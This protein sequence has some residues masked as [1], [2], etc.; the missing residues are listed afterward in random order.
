VIGS[1][2]RGLTVQSIGR[3]S[4]SFFSSEFALNTLCLQA[5]AA[6]LVASR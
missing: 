6:Y 5:F 2:L 4:Q 3:T 1:C